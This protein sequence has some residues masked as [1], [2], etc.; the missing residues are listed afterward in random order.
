[1][2]KLIPLIVLVCASFAQAQS[3]DARIDSFVLNDTPLGDAV[4]LITDAT[5]VPLVCTSEAAKVSISINLSNASLEAVL[6]AM[7]RANGLW[8]G[9]SPGQEIIII[10]TLRQHLASQSIYSNDT[11]ESITVKYPSVLD[12][13][14]TIKGLFRDKVVWERPD[15]DQIDPYDRIERALGRLDL[16]NER[17]QFD[18]LEQSSSSSS[19]GSSDFEEIEDTTDEQIRNLREVNQSRTA[20][21][22]EHV[23]SSLM[24]P[25]DTATS[26]VYISVLPEVNTLLIRS[27]DRDAVRAVKAAITSIDKP[28]GQVLLEV[29]VLSID[30]TDRKETGVEWLF[31]DVKGFSGGF[32]D[33]AIR[34]I[35]GAGIADYVTDPRTPTVGYVSDRFQARLKMVAENRNIRQLA[36]PTLLVADNE[37]AN[38]FVGSTIKIPDS[39]IPGQIAAGTEG[40]EA[41][42]TEPTVALKEQE[43]GLTL[44]LAP[45]V[46]ADSSVT[47]RILQE[48][49]REG[50]SR[51]IIYDNKSLIT[52][53]DIDQELVASTLVVENND[54]I[55]LGGMISENNTDVVRG[56]P[57]LMDIPY[58]GHLF[59]TTAKE[60]RR[61]E[62]IVLIRPHVITIPGEAGVAS[63][64][65]LDRQRSSLGIEIDGLLE[66]L[67]SDEEGET[68]PLLSSL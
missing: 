8:M 12:V 11:I 9:R 53:I 19:S 36:S 7:C 31:G 66:P 38:V 14:D 56:I 64:K 42:K 4:R 35:D 63:K 13:A 3:L 60:N 43:I 21:L 23:D 28:R 51:D 34:S 45:R 67:A 46:H 20:F 54:L 24:A 10:S 32:A 59:K 47:L 37:A 58:L 6:E 25:S 40:G 55:Y 61:E 18:V 57:Y 16:T 27:S 68:A 52:V 22:Q 17:S 41:L 48:R 44:L 62:L 1:M 30:I 15:S 49:A 50:A 29:S 26:L 39:I 65:L 2:K 33:S 5:K